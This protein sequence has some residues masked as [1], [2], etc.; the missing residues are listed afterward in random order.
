MLP[1]LLLPIDRPDSNKLDDVYEVAADIATQANGTTIMVPKFFQYDGASIPAAAWQLVGTPFHPRLMVA[2][3]F[4]DWIYHTHRIS[5]PAAD[6]L[7]EHLLIDSG[8][9]PVKAGLMK[10]A[11]SIFGEHYWH[12][13]PDDIRYIQRLARRIRQDGRNPADY[14]I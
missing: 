5:R 4:H 8:V 13:D 7:F 6:G 3:V 11:V 2:S 1:L 10:A 9:K 12:N 14:G